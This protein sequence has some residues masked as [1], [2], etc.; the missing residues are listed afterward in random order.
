[1]FDQSI[2]QIV[3]AFEIPVAMGACTYMA[4]GCEAFLDWQIACTH[5]PATKS[6]ASGHAEAFLCI[7]NASGDMING[8]ELKFI[9]LLA[10]P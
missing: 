9:T 6:L 10:H 5:V 1:M 2:Q 7:L 8:Y 4:A 3:A